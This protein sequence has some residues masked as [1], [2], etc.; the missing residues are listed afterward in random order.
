MFKIGFALFVVL[1]LASCGQGDDYYY[2]YD[3]IAEC[4]HF[5]K[6]IDNLTIIKSI[7]YPEASK[8]ITYDSA[9]AQRLLVSAYANTRVKITTNKGEFDLLINPDSRAYYGPTDIFYYGYDILN[10]N[11]NYFMK[12]SKIEIKNPDKSYGKIYLDTL[13]FK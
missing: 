12:T 8:L 10:H 5:I 2:Y 3:E 1:V 11:F 13:Y 7:E 4:K 9:G 6:P